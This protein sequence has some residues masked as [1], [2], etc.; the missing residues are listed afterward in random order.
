MPVLSSS[1][2]TLPGALRANRQM[3]LVAYDDPFGRVAALLSAYAIL[4]SNLI[5]MQSALL[6]ANASGVTLSSLS[7][8]TFSIMPTISNFSTT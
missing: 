2:T 6:S 8:V 7:T 1:L 3:G 4:A 5:V